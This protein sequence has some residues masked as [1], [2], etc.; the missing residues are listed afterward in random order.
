MKLLFETAK[1]VEE[2]KV[3]TPDAKQNVIPFNGVSFEKRHTS[4][5]Y[6]YT[7]ESGQFKSI[8]MHFKFIII[9]DQ[10]KC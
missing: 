4:K 9:V 6:V 10:R 1:V 2:Y 3:V 5:G 8:V 7:F